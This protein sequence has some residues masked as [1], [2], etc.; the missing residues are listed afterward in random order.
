MH[1]ARLAA[2]L[3]AHQPLLAHQLPEPVRGRLHALAVGHGVEEHDRGLD[4]VGVRLA[5]AVDRRPAELGRASHPRVVDARAQQHGE[6]ARGGDQHAVLALLPPRRVR[7]GPLARERQGH[8]ALVGGHGLQVVGHLAGQVLADAAG[9][10]EDLQRHV[11]VRR[12]ARRPTAVGLERVAEA[13]VGR[14]VAEHGG[15]HRLRRRAL[16]QVLEA[17]L[18]QHPGGPQM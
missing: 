2:E 6:R 11:D 3:A 15:A 1:L 14:A 12:L 17:P 5:D 10:L 7:V 9:L 8:S 16:E 13:A 4:L 18:L